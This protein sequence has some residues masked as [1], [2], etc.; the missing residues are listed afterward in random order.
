VLSPANLERQ[1]LLEPAPVQDLLARHGRRE[2]DLSRQIWG[3]LGL[4]LWFDS[5]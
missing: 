2:E 3:L 5:A 1:G 4:T